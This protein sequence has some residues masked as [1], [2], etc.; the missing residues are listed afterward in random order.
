[1]IREIATLTID[2]ANA[3]QFEKAVLEARPIFL[4]AD[5]CHEVH[6]ERV[7]ELPGRYHLVVV[8]ETVEAHT[9]I[10][11]NSPAFQQW[12]GLASPWFIKPP[13]VVH[14]ALVA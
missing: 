13:E 12:R 9:E 1:M 14:T 4:A 2:P 8:W 6:L 5:G 7:I 10:F 3:D 11:R